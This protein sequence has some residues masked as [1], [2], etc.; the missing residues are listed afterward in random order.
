MYT[1]KHF[2]EKDLVA[3]HAVMAANSFALVCVSDQGG[4]DAAHVPVV[5][6]PNVGEFGELHFHVAKQNTIWQAFDGQ[7]EARVI[8]SGPHA[9]ISADWYDSENLVPTW[10]YIA[11]HAMGVPSVISED[12]NAALLDTL[13]AQEEAH[14]AP[15]PPWT[16]AKM[17]SDLH[18]R[19]LGGI[20]GLSMPIG[21]LEAKAKLS[22]NRPDK[23]KTG[24]IRGLRQRGGDMEQAIA[25][26][27][28]AG[29][30]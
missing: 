17:D 1:P 16:T 2:E 23:D 24:V 15:K 26:L 9:Y 29:P 21:T 4:I 28:E 20:V 22:Q 30:L 6:D 19:M 8:F 25:S 5:L 7:R 12:Q 10:N 11:V 3:A 14:L 13:A 27:M 18:K